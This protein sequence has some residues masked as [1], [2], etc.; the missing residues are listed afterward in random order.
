MRGVAK[1]RELVFEGAPTAAQ[2]G[3]TLPLETQA[4]RVC[5]TALEMLIRLIAVG[6][7]VNALRDPRRLKLIESAHLAW[8]AWRG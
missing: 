5:V 6:V 4:D 3:A 8:R 2:A 7:P 1:Q